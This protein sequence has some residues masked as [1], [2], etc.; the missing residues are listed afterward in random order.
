MGREIE[1]EMGT[2]TDRQVDSLVQTDMQIMRLVVRWVD[3]RI[4]GQSGR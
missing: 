4:E 1:S 2:E 3:I